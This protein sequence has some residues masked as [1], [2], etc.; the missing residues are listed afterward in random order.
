P[1]VGACTW[2]RGQHTAQP[3]LGGAGGTVAEVGC[4]PAIAYAAKGGASSRSS[5]G[6]TSPLYHRPT[7]LSE[8]PHLRPPHGLTQL[9]P[10]DQ[11]HGDG[12]VCAV[13]RSLSAAAPDRELWGEGLQHCTILDRSVYSAAWAIIGTQLVD[14]SMIAD[15]VPDAHKRGGV[16]LA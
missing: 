3:R 16:A 5:R 6:A 7:S 4:S 11:Q 13:L 9:E 10:A 14:G 8:T 2:S 15:E 1:L 12:M